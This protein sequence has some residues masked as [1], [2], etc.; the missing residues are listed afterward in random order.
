MTPCND[1]SW[2]PGPE[3]LAAYFD[4]EFEGRDDLAE[5]R[6]RLE[7]WLAGSPSA[8][9]EL[10]DYRHLKKL[11]HETAPAE[12]DPSAWAQ[13]RAHL[14][15]CVQGPVSARPTSRKRSWRSTTLVACAASVML[16]LFI[17]SRLAEGPDDAPFPV[18]AEH[19]VV[20]LHVE[21]ADTGTLVVGELPLKGPL[22]LVG[23]GDMTVTSVQPAQRDNMVPEVHV[24]ESGRPIIWARAD[25]EED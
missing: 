14:E 1:G 4:G 16:A 17:G 12:P 19:E 23:P 5:L 11:W 24:A 18:A 22:E 8:Q 2:S 9:K 20:I 6:Q 7:N 21:G 15:A 10:A 3:L 13:I 25:W